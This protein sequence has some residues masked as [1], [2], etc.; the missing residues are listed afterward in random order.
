MR[1]RLLF[2]FH[3]PPSF[4]FFGIRFGQGSLLKRYF[5]IFVPNSAQVA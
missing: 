2:L 3:C 5:L 4:H 1:G